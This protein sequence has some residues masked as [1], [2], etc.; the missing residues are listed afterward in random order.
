MI[1]N[2]GDC[3]Q[4]WTNGQLRSTR[5]RVHI[6][7]S[8]LDADPNAVLAERF[9]VA[10]FAKPNRSC[11]IQSLAAEC[12]PGEQTVGEFML[13]RSSTSLSGEQHCLPLADFRLCGQAPLA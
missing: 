11:S 4:R 10:Y 7:Q 9:S 2:L 13:Q 6:A 3:L 5:H 12:P 1:V 8:D